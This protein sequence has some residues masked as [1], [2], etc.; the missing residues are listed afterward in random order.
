M[1]KNGH[2]FSVGEMSMRVVAPVAGGAS[3][4]VGAASERKMPGRS[5]RTVASA[6][7]RRRFA[8]RRADGRP[9]VF[10]PGG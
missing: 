2:D 4:A 6:I 5:T 3:V 1:S 9:V 8:V 10:T 7:A